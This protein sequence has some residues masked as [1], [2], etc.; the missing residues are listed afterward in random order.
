[1]ISMLPDTQQ[2]RCIPSRWEL[3]MPQEKNNTDR[4]WINFF[5]SE[6]KTNSSI[7]MFVPYHQDWFLVREDLN[8]Q[9]GLYCYSGLVCGCLVVG[10]S[11]ASIIWERF[12]TLKLF[13]TPRFLVSLEIYVYFVYPAP[14][15]N[16][17]KESCRLLNSSI[18]WKKITRRTKTACRPS[19]HMGRLFVC[20]RV[21]IALV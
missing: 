8:V 10:C 16:Q 2:G 9:N 5:C 4:L 21:N 13:L 14:R 1:M 11:R 3:W 15:K 17:G 6:I 7:C 19:T 18:I 12:L 20:T